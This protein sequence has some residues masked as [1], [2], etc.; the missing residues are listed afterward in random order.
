MDELDEQILSCLEEIAG[1]DIIKTFKTKGSFLELLDE[2]EN[3]NN[4]LSTN[5]QKE[6]IAFKFPINLLNTLCREHFG[7]EFQE[8]IKE[9]KYD[10]KLVLVNDRMKIDRDL[11][12]TFISKVASDIVKDI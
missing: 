10:N 5:S 12:V 9:S 1:K 2:F 8:K 6:N 11:I 4:L 3:I 7:K